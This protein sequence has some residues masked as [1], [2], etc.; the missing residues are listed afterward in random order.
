[1][2]VWA[3]AMLEGMLRG[4]DWESVLSFDP[5]QPRDQTGVSRLGLYWLSSVAGS[6][7]LSF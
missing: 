7:I 1:M 6:S 2:F 3:C 5:G 4:T